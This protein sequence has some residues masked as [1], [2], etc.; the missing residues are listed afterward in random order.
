MQRIV[1]KG[2]RDDK[3]HRDVEGTYMRLDIPQI[4]PHL[5]SQLEERRQGWSL[6]CL[7]DTVCI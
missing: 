2:L 7:F 1:D 4:M 6:R 3:W 5:L